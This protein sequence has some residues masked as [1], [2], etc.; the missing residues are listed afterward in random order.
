MS[1]RLV[2]VMELFAEGNIR[3]YFGDRADWRDS[4]FYI[5]SFSL[6]GQVSQLSD[7][8]GEAELGL[9]EEALPGCARS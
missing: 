4:A 3:R 7:D 8:P 6:E 2:R 9:V 5:R 1:F